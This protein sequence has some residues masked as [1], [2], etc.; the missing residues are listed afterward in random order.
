MPGMIVGGVL[1]SGDTV[2]VASSRPQGRVSALRRESGKQIWRTSTPTIGAPL[3]LLDGT[4]IALAERGEVLGIDPAT[5]KIRWH[6]RV[7]VARTAAVSAGPGQMLIA[8]TDSLYR[9]SSANGE[10]AQRAV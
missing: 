8:T 7:G 6:R 2:Y 3:A 9:V 5:G 10:I 1:L 4:L